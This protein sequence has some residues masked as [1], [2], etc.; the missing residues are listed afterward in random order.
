M[1]LSSGKKD[2]GAARQFVCGDLVRDRL[3]GVRHGL[4][5]RTWLARF[6]RIHIHRSTTARPSSKSYTCSHESGERSPLRALVACAEAGTSSPL[7][8]QM[9]NPDSLGYFEHSSPQ[10]VLV[11]STH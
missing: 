8:G 6:A 5:D 7:L 11:F 2:E 1:L 3:F 10:N 4:A 9:A